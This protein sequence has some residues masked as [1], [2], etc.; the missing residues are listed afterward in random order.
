MAKKKFILFIVEGN[1]DKRELEAMFHTP[2]FSEYLEHYEPYYLV[3][4]KDITADKTVN[5]GNIQ[6]KL[7]DIVMR[8][9]KNGI[10]YSNVKVSDI[11]EVVHIVDL[12]GAFIPLDNILGGD[13]SKFIYT[14][15]NIFTSNVDGARGRNKKKSEILKKL[16]YVN[17]IGNIPYSIYFVS[18]NMDHVLFNNRMMDKNGKNDSSFKF[19]IE[20]Q[21]NPNSLR[22][23]IFND[24]VATNQSYYESWERVQNECESLKRLTNLNLFFGQN[25]KNKK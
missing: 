10:P 17:Q 22:D 6:Q 7:N 4:N 18:C 3:Q 16:I 21:K 8:F 13:S 24:V 9:R 5:A 19:Q 2:F 20:C 12:D 14:D 23:S 25:A 11:Q 15:T 1:N